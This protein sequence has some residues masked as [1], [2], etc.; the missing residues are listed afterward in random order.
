LAIHF[1]HQAEHSMGGR[2]RRSHIEDHFLPFHIGEVSLTGGDLSPCALGGMPCRHS[3]CRIF[4]F[5]CFAAHFSPVTAG[6]WSSARFKS[7]RLSS[8]EMVFNSSPSGVLTL[9]SRAIASFPPGA[10]TN[11]PPSSG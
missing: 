1:Q 3:S 4:V 7:R 9:G 5:Q 2:M 10:V 11:G 6:F 8:R